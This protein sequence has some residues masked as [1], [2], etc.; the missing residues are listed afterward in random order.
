[1]TQ[2]ELNAA[3]IQKLAPILDECTDEEEVERARRMLVALVDGF[4]DQYKILVDNR[5]ERI[6]TA[7]LGGLFSWSD[8]AAVNDVGVVAM[9]SVWTADALIAELDKPPNVIAPDHGGAAD[10][11][12]DTQGDER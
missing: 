7:V 2:E 5:R 6:A 8:V 10:Y 1:M 12:C 9:R 4:V 11:V 3:M